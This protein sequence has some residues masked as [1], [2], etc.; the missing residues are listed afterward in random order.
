MKRHVA[1]RDPTAIIAPLGLIQAIALLV[2]TGIVV[3]IGWLR[4]RVR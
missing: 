3:G 2:V 4:G 1:G